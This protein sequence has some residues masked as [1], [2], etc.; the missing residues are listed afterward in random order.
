MRLEGFWRRGDARTHTPRAHTFGR[1]IA[2]GGDVSHG[3]CAARAGVCAHT[4]ASRTKIGDAK[5]SDYSGVGSLRFFVSLPQPPP[6]PPSLPSPLPP[7]T[8]APGNR[9]PSRFSMKRI[10]GIAALLAVATALWVAA[11]RSDLG[12]RD[13]LIVALV[14]VRGGEGQ[15]GGERKNQHATIPTLPPT[16][17]SP[18]SRSSPWASTLSHSSSLASPPSATAPPTRTHSKATSRRRGLTSRRGACRCRNSE[19]CASTHSAQRRD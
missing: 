9:A 4:R 15:T 8:R 7:L 3:V 2:V 18:S 11:L 14:R 6:A 12:D 19:T 1:R 16:I 5:E 13:R 17:S 10:Y